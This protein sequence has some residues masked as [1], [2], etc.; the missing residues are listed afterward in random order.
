MDVA[1]KTSAT[2]TIILASNSTFITSCPLLIPDSTINWN[3]G[4]IQFR[5]VLDGNIMLANATVRSGANQTPH[6][7]VELPAVG[8]L[9]REMSRVRVQ[10]S[11]CA[12][13]SEASPIGWT[14]GARGSSPRKGTAVPEEP[15][16]RSSVRQSRGPNDTSST[17]LHRPT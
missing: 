7:G 2:N 13:S 14:L 5:H 16:R 17:F 9:H 15:S 4:R 8:G 1:V 12:D 10:E 11:D 3:G 6:F